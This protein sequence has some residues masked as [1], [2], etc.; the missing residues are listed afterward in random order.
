MT[1]SPSKRVP[2]L[3]GRGLGDEADHRA[4]QVRPG[5]ADPVQLDLHEPSAASTTSMPASSAAA[6]EWWRPGRS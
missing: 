3:L 2:R 6:G 1:T 5:S 4:L